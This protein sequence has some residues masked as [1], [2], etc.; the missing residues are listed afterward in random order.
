MD[1]MIFLNYIA[2]SIK[3]SDENMND[4]GNFVLFV[5]ALIVGAYLL[6]VLISIFFWRRSVKKRCKTILP[7]IIW[8]SI[9]SIPTLVWLVSLLLP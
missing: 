1:S 7:W 9:L 6:I 3:L 2:G 5:S 4:I 8:F